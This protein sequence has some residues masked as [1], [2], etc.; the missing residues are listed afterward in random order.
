MPSS[1]IK[2]IRYHRAEQLLCI[3]FVSGTL[4][5]YRQVPEDIYAHFRRATSK[6]RYFNQYIK[7]KYPFKRIKMH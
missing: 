5:H 6:G 4:Y 1:V 2:S 3:R 7:G